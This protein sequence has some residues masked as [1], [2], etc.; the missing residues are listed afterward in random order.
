MLQQILNGFGLAGMTIAQFGQPHFVGAFHA[1][2]LFFSGQ[3]AVSLSACQL[4][5][6]SASQLVSLSACQLIS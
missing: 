3:L 1:K 6:L 5:S 2:I 4:V